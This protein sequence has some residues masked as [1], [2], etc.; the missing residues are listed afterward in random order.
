MKK[1]VAL[2]CSLLLLTSLCACTQKQTEKSSEEKMI[3]LQDS[4]WKYVTDQ[5]TTE[6][7]DGSILVTLTAPDYSAIIEQLSNRKD[8]NI[9]NA[10]LIEAPSA[11]PNYI[12]EY[13]LTV[14]SADEASV[15]QALLD[16]IACELV[17]LTLS[18]LEG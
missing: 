10:M 5:Q 3:S 9:T 16:Q 15:K 17:A 14:D 2:L 12:K 1:Y 7:D 6:L 8:E 11:Y 4:C 13:T 18:K